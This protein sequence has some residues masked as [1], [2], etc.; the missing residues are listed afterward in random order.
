MRKY[1]GLVFLVVGLFF[2]EGASIRIAGRRA[3]VQFEQVMQQLR[4]ADFEGKTG[5]P[6]DARLAPWLPYAVLSVA[7][8][9]AG[10]WFLVSKP[11][12]APKAN[13]Q[14]QPPAA[15]GGGTD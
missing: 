13:G 8:F 10:L 7:S 4:S 11:R 9:A 2:L 15:P 6:P 1:I 14:A 3:E 5:E 12:A